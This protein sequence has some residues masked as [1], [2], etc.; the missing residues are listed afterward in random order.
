[1]SKCSEIEIACDSL[2]TFFCEVLRIY[3]GLAGGGVAFF[4]CGGADLTSGA[5]SGSIS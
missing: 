3:L 1:M 2:T 5:D 4:G